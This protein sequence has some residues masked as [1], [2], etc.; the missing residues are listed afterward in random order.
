VNP[1]LQALLFC[2]RQETS[3]PKKHRGPAFPIVPDSK[4]ALPFPLKS[5]NA[6]FP[7]E[8][9]KA[10][11]C[12][13]AD[14]TRSTASPRYTEARCFTLCLP[15][16]ESH[17][18]CTTAGIPAPLMIGNLDS[19]KARR[20]TPHSAQRPNTPHCDSRR[21]IKALSKRRNSS[22]PLRGEKR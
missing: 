12:Y 2:W 4:R 17:L 1:R 19:A 3:L 5:K 11:M 8:V 20:P 22:P 9:R 21:A 18:S 14:S 6:S 15:A 13:I 10:V 7:I 16:E